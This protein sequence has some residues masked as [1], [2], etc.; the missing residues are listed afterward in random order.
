[1]KIDGP[2]DHSDRLSTQKLS[3]KVY[4]ER[5]DCST[6]DILLSEIKS[7]FINSTML[8]ASISPAK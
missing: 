4:I 7:K 3:N 8:A 6:A 5:L 2:S 1:M